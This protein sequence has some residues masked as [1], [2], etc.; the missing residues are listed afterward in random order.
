MI[1]LKKIVLALGACGVMASGSVW[2]DIKVGALFPFSG[3]LALLG[4]ESF[5]GL[6]VAVNEINAAGGVNGEKVTIVKADAVDPTQAVS[7][8]K[9]LISEGVVGVFGSY[10]SGVSYAATPVTELAGVPYFEMGATAHKVTTRGYKYLFAATPT[11]RFMALRSSMH[12]TT[13]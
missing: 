6:E 8:T 13:S 3:N 11:L 9:R 10:A 4:Q 5:R 7:E 1:K 2:A 12:C